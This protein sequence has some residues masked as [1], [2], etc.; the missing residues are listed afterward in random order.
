MSEYA[1]PLWPLPEG[2]TK[3]K[4]RINKAGLFETHYANGV[5]GVAERF[6][7]DAINYAQ[8]E[9]RFLSIHSEYTRRR[10]ALAKFLCDLVYGEGAWDQ[11][12]WD[13]NTDLLLNYRL[14][15]DEI[16]KA[17]PH[18]LSLGERERLASQIPELAYP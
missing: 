18:L 7:E 2:Q 11:A 5:V 8:D 10:E 1:K 17:N 9:V 16:I 4:V 12:G 15:A 3:P 13:E 14:D 6:L